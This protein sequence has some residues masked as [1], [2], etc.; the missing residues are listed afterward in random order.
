MLQLA[1]HDPKTPAS[2]D[3]IRR[4]SP[5]GRANPTMRRAMHRRALIERAHRGSC[6]IDGAAAEPDNLIGLAVVAQKL[7]GKPTANDAK[8]VADWREKVFQWARVQYHK[9][10]LAHELGHAM[11]LRHNFAAS[12]D[13]L[14]YDIQYW[15]LRTHNGTVT[16]DCPKGTTDGTNC[17]APRWRDPISKEELDNNIGMYATTSVMDYPGDP[18]QDQRLL[19]KYDRAAV[20]LIYGDVVDV[21][22]EPGVTVTGKKNAA[23]TAKAYKLSAFASHPGLTGIYFF[24]NVDPDKPSD[25]IHYSQYHNAFKLITGCKKSDAP[26]AIFGEKCSEQ[27]LD[28]VDYRDMSPFAENPTYAV[29]S[30]GTAAR[31]KDK[32]GRVRRGYLFSSDEYADAGNV[33]TFTDDAGA[34]A[35]EIVRFLQSQYELRYVLDSFRRNRVTFNSAD[36]TWRLQSHYFDPIELIAKTF[37][38]GALLDGDPTAPPSSMLKD[39]YYGPLALAASVGLDMFAQI[40]TRPQPGYFCSPD[41]YCGKQPY[42]VDPVLYSADAAPLPDVYGYNF[43]VALGNGR[44]LHNEFDYKQGYWWGDYQTQ[45]GSYYEKVWATYYLSEAFDWFISNSKEDFVDSRYKNVNFATVFPEQVRR[46]YNSLLTDDFES[47]APRAMG[48]AKSQKDAPAVPVLY[49]TWSGSDLGTFPKGALLVDPHWGWNARVWAMVWGAMYFPTN[50][51]YDWVHQARIAA[52]PTE[53]PNWPDDEVYAFSDPKSGLTYRARSSGTEKLAGLT[54][55]KSAGARML[56]WANRLLAIA[57]K[58]QRDGNGNPVLD[59]Y[60]RPVLELKSGKPQL[61]DKNPGAEAVLKAYVDQI[62]MF[63]QITATFQQPLEGLPSP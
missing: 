54:R 16:E 1:G 6:R 22:A 35:F 36:T 7:F 46:L 23:G 60:G 5:F 15:Q 33:T 58:V 62:D 25:N 38:F 21:W 18:S 55:Q 41:E 27:P 37:A 8:A 10:V 56:E 51:S 47:Y 13:S 42:G 44:Y 4:A 34:D 52:L 43:Q 29:F 48:K 63:R 24:P 49:P 61:D 50:W 9:G 45:V 30:W 53:Q 3:A 11:G 26:G 20:R 31:T 14:N 39:G 17:I 32:Q 59:K 40:I 19:G 28:V 57:Y 2:A 12:F